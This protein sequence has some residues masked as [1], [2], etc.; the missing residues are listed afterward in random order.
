MYPINGVRHF[1]PPPSS[2]VSSLPTSLFPLSYPF[3]LTHPK[4]SRTAWSS[5]VLIQGAQFYAQFWY[6][7]ERLEQ[8]RED[9][10][11]VALKRLTGSGRGVEP[12]PAR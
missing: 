10:A 3:S 12:P 1:F 8:A 6:A 11:E 2:L 5:I 7:G 4:G 9:A